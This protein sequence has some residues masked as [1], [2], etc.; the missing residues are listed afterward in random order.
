MTSPNLSATPAQIGWRLV[1]LIYDIWP[2]LALWLAASA[3]MLF[4][5]GGELVTP[6]SAAALLEAV[7]LWTVTGVYLV[8]SWSRGGA[9]LGMRPWRLRVVTASGQTAR[10]TALAARYAWSTAPALLTL[11]LAALL[12]WHTPYMPFWLA[13][14]VALM[15]PLWSLFNDD[16]AA[17][18]DQLSGT[19]FVR[20]TAAA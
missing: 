10:W 18:Y 3:L 14:A 1:A 17:L 11:E 2:I 16:R 7:W 20:L 9:T 13:S 12:P 5:R 15:G 19:R 4:L 8:L 6:G